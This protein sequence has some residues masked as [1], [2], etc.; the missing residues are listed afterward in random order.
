MLTYT[1][2][3]HVKQL[4]VKINWTILKSLIL[5]FY[6]VKKKKLTFYN[7]IFIFEIFNKYS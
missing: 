5:T 6:F 7:T 1:L 4:N 3:I 2:K